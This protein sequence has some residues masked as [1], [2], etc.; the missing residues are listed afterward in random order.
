MIVSCL[1]Q[2]ITI[3][4]TGILVE[5][6]NDLR[7]NRLTQD[8]LTLPSAVLFFSLF[9]LLLN[10]LHMLK[11][12]V[13]NNRQEKGVYLLRG[14]IFVAALLISY[15]VGVGLDD[16]KIF[17]N[18]IEYN[19]SLVAFIIAIAYGYSGRYLSN[20]IDNYGESTAFVSNK[21]RNICNLVAFSMFVRMVLFF[22]DVQNLLGN[23]A[24]IYSLSILE[25]WMIVP[26]GVSIHFLHQK[27]SS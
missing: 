15:A 8:F 5:D 20:V 13:E 12:E 16:S 22:P 23:A 2:S 7:G 1:V 25:M 10:I 14:I 3:I 21:L 18:A 26:Y 17:V 27:N 19:S 4:V 24:G 9:G 6:N 11:D